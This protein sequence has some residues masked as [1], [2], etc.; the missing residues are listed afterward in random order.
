MMNSD[1]PLTSPESGALDGEPAPAGGPIRLTLVDVARAAGVSLATVDRVINRR[2]GVSAR[3]VAKVEESLAKLGYRPDPVAAQLAR[4]TTFRFCFLLPMG[5]NSFMRQLS[6]QIQQTGDWLKEQRA[7]V[8]VQ[9]VD[10]FDPLAL[11]RA[12]DGLGETYQGGAVVA[13]DRCVG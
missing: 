13:L 8:E 7:F 11:A 3:A 9:Q 5:N 4:R 12:L 2:P 6:E 10:V 1:L